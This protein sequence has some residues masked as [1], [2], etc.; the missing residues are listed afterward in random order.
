MKHESILKLILP[1]VFVIIIGTFGYIT[2]EDWTFV[3]SLYMTVITLTTVGFGE[4]HELSSSG[5]IFTI[6]LIISGVGIATYTFTKIVGLIVEGELFRT[7]QR[8]K[9]ENIIKDLND[10]IILCGY[11]R[12]GRIVH[13]ELVQTKEKI[14]VIETSDAANN[15]LVS[16]GFLT[17]K[18]SAYDDDILKLAGIDKAKVL[19]TLLSSD[20]DNI[21]VTLCARDLNPNIKIV[22]RTE[23]EHSEARLKRAGATEI[24]APYRISGNK[25]VQKIM[26][27]YVSDFLEITGTNKKQNIMIEEV[28]IPLDSKIV[29]KS[30]EDSNIRAKTGA[31]IAAIIS[32]KGEMTF[33]PTGKDIIEGNSTMI[34]LGQED[35][36]KKFNS[37]F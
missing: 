32:S 27:P 35:A 25:I 24:I 10:H 12:L 21:Y 34:V 30:I 3:D 22:A 29:G 1:V 2:I 36:L 37:I 5:R 7:R 11:G 8:K 17:I 16:K 19:L 4:I 6:F 9:M 20:A 26:R 31:M 28:V 33:N 15:E 14:V 13:K 23:E 18:G